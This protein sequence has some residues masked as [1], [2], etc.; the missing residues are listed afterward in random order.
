MHPS[1]LGGS[2]ALATAVPVRLIF[3]FLNALIQKLFVQG[4]PSMSWS[5]LGAHGDFLA[6]DITRKSE[7]EVRF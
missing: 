6:G 3:L 1:P 2:R 4:S 7:K 5:T